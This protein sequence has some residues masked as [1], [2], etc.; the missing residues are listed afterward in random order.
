[1][2]VCK[3]NDWVYAH[4]ILDIIIYANNYLKIQ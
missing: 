2:Q 3:K 4:K 1:M